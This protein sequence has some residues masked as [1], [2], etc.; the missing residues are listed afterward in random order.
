MLGKE[1]RPDKSKDVR[2]YYAHRVAAL[3]ILKKLS[4]SGIR[5]NWCLYVKRCIDVFNL[6][7]YII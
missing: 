2:T 7:S 4:T 1:E 5:Y 6:N 3:L